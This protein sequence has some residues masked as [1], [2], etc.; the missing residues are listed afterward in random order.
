MTE[1]IITEDFPKNEVQFAKRF[2]T[3]E[4]CRQYLF[5][6]RWPDGFVCQKCGH[7]TY[8][9]SAR[10]L[11]ICYRCEHQ[12]SLTAGTIMHGTRKPLT[13]WFKALWWFTTRKSGVNAINLMDLLGL[14]GYSTAWTWLQKIR[15][16]TVR[17]ERG[18]LFGY[19]EVDEFYIG[20]QKSGKRGRGANGKTA[21]V[22]AVEKL[23]GALGRVRIEVIPDCSSEFLNPFIEKN[24]QPGSHVVTDGWKGY[25]S[26]DETIYEHHRVYVNKS[27]SKDSVLP[28]VHLV[29][30]LVKRLILGTF[31]GRFEPRY[32]QKYLDEYVFRF[33]RRRSLRVGKK[34]MRIIQQVA[35]SGKLTLRQIIQRAHLSDPFPTASSLE[36]IG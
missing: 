30:S 1:F 19:V 2:S 12:H 16:C 27:S 35:V 11:Y 25:D 26:I 6:A 28:G 9:K 18:K 4:A 7:N 23:P 20:G 34:F 14:G 24:I 5:D 29:A 17:K 21:V 36:G 8:W 10:D 33:N 3:E 13:L 31:Q 22:V 15:N 32:L